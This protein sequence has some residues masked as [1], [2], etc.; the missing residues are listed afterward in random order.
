MAFTQK[1]IDLTI[2]LAQAP[3]TNQ[4]PTFSG[5]GGNQVTLSNSR[6]SVRIRNAGSGTQNQAQVR[7][8]GLAP[9]L[10]NELATL[11][12]AFNI[13]PKNTITIMA[14]DTYPLS[15]VF[16]GTIWAAYGNYDEAPDVPFTFECTAGVAQL[17][18]NAA[19]TSFTQATSAA[20][21]M[22]SIAQKM[23][24]NFENNNVNAMLRSGG[25]GGPYFK[26]S[27][28]QQARMCAEAGNFYWGVFNGVTLAIWPKGGF[29]SAPPTPVIAPPPLGEMIGYPAFTQSGLIVR[30]VFNPQIVFGGQIQVQS[31]LLSGIASAQQGIAAQ[32][33]SNL[34]VGG[35]FAPYKFATDG[36]WAVNKVDMDLDSQVPG[37]QWMTTAYAYN[38][39]YQKTL[40]SPS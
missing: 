21:V 5:T 25:G 14:G 7:I 34:K 20:D 2:Q 27:L 6:V 36:I 4:A 8:Y 23:G 26:G 33:I 40:P 19:P 32:Q 28:W 1:L 12:V 18:A 38:P 15:T 35:T 22:Q 30:S 3:G 29:R 10:M 16:V 11:G 9:S 37:G 13:V 17:T 31:S 24:L 39:N